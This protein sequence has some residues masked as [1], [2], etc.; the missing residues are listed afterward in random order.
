M[1]RKIAGIMMAV[2]VSAAM[3]V[4]MIGCG[5]LGGV[6]PSITQDDNDGTE[7]NESKPEDDETSASD[8]DTENGSGS[9]NAS[10]AENGSGSGNS[11][12]AENGSGSENGSE[13]ENGSGAG[14]ETQGSAEVIPYYIDLDSVDAYGNSVTTD[15][16]LSNAK[17]VM[18]NFWE[19]WCGPCVGEIPDLEL[20]Y[21]NYK[22]RGLVIIGLY[23]SSDMLDDIQYIIEA[24]G[25]TYPVVE[26]SSDTYRFM[27]EYVPT[28]CFLDHYGSPLP[29]NQ[30]IGARSY[31]EWASI[32]EYYLKSL[33]E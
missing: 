1:K 7:N 5:A 22:D 19:P 27:S 21:E 20:L 15:E 18:I 4:T 16:L 29:D 12:E 24:D 25:L 10:E 3:S 32:V 6:N 31:S 26:A 14:N 28:T 33:D 2:A 30:Y 17:I 23:T 8:A 11:S 9:G 13:A